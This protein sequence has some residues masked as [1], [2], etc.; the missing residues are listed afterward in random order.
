MENEIIMNI[1]LQ[2][3]IKRKTKIY[4]RLHNIHGK[5]KANKDI[6]ENHLC[7]NGIRKTKEKQAI[8]MAEELEMK[9]KMKM[10]S[11]IL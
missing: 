9:S 11:P 1:Y 2:C 3:D 8:L 7:C 5:R 4:L 6:L 10:V